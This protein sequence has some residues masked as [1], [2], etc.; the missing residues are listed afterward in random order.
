LTHEEA[1][2]CMATLAKYGEIRGRLANRKFQSNLE[3]TNSA[4]FATFHDRLVPE[5]DAMRILA[6]YGIR[7]PPF[8]LAHGANEAVSIAEEI[9]YPVALKVVSPDIIHKSEVGGVKL[10]L[11]NGDHVRRAYDEIFRNISTH[12]G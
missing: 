1:V 7:S 12:E 10:G 5:P 8:K 11:V 9:G 6:E 3:E 4:R 2:K